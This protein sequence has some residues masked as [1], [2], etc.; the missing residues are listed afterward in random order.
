MLLS[1]VLDASYG[2]IL[3]TARLSVLVLLLLESVDD[4]VLL[5]VA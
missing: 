4:A 3:G 1:G 5:H 2:W